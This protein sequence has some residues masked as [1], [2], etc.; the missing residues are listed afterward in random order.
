MNDV[1]NNDLIERSASVIHLNK[2]GDFTVGDVGCALL[3]DKGNIFTGVAIDAPSGMGFCAEVN[4]IAAM[5]TAGETTIKK[6]VA[7]WKNENDVYIVSPCGK[8]RQF[9]SFINEENMDTDV[10]LGKEETVKLKDLL[11][12]FNEYNKI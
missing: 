12:H 1:T 8:C 11:P 2:I 7:T 4:A 6:I 5:V 3:T 9:M 10:I